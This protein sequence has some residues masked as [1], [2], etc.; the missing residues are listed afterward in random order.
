MRMTVAISRTAAQGSG[1][2]DIACVDQC[3][4]KPFVPRWAHMTLFNVSLGDAGSTGDA[5]MAD[6]ATLAARQQALQTDGAAPSTATVEDPRLGEAVTV[7]GDG[8]TVNQA[9]S[10]ATTTLRLAWA[11]AGAGADVQGLL[12]IE[13]CPP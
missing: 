11:I 5:M 1:D 10:P 3:T 8:F 13:G 2:Q 4:L 12:V 9:A 6:G 7:A